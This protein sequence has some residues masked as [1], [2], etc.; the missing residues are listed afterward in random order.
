MVNVTPFLTIYAMLW[1]E[2]GVS[3]LLCV[4]FDI[5]ISMAENQPTTKQVVLFAVI[6][7]FLVSVIGTVLALG[8]FGP[9]FGV[10]ESDGGPILFNRPRILE[11]ITETITD[12]E[13]Q[14]KVI[15]QEELVVGVVEQTSGAVVS[16]VATKDVPVV[17]QFFIDPFGGDPFFRRFFGD[18]DFRVP[19]LRQK[20]TEKQEVSSGTGFLVSADGLV[21]TNKHV[22]S[23]LEAEYTVLLNDGKKLP[24]KVFARAP[25][26][27]LAG[28]KV[29]GKDMP[30][31]R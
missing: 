21:L 2:S 5:I 19:Q 31:C 7:S 11:K 24:A 9:I 4:G 15:R 28:L 3:C 6:L 20:G 8:V 22:V 18:D 16:V 10:G 12:R 26:E 13:V 29:E 27:D 1:K 14:E 23:D 25:V 17:E 30:Y